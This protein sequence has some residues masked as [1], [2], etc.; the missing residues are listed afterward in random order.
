[1]CVRYQR[2]K[3]CHGSVPTVF[4]ADVYPKVSPQ[5]PNAELIVFKFPIFIPLLRHLSELEKWLLR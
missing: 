2:E 1:M 5:R 4:L 3:L